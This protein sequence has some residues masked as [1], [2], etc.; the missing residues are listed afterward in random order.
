[1][2]TTTTKVLRAC[3]VERGR[4]LEEKRLEAGEALTIGTGAKNTFVVTESIGPDD[5][6]RGHA[7]IAQRNGAYELVLENGMRTKLLVEGRELDIDGLRGAGLLSVEADTQRVRLTDESRGKVSVGPYTVVF[8]FAPQLPAARPM[9]LPAELKPNYIK[10]LDRLY[11]LTL[12]GTTALA[13]LLILWFQFVPQP[14]EVT[15][16]TMDDRWA[17]LIVPDYVPEKP[18]AEEKPKGDQPPPTRED[19]KEKVAKPEEKVDPAQAKAERT[20]KIRKSI[21]GQG[22]LAI[23]GTR[24]AGASGAVA[25][26]FRDSNINGDLETAFE[27]ISG[28]GVATTG[29]HGARG[30]GTTGTGDAASIGGIATSGGGQVGLGGKKETRVAAVKTEAPEVDGSLDGDAIAKVVRARLRSIQD[31]YEHE[32]KRDS[33]LQGKIEIEF[34]IGGSGEVEDAHVSANKMGS[35]AV[36]DCIVARVRR[37]RFPQPDGGRVTVNYPFIFTPSS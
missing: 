15:F 25:D 35:A 37:W 14:A 7:L 20:E 21:Q 12:A 19:A 13:L 34:T 4:I 6:G 16:E 17:K 10:N 27:G 28:V 11:A 8:Q 9:P 32:L 36:G 26:V 18:R 2:G 3:V 5:D 31:C 30:G 1:M 33:S 22:V 24:G 29:A 23:L